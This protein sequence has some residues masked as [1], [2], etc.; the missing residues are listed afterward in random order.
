MKDEMKVVSQGLIHTWEQDFLSD[1]WELKRDGKL[2]GAAE[3]VGGSW[4][5]TDA[6]GIVIAFR[7]DEKTARHCLEL[8]VV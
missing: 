6:E 3:P 7:P 8:L 1:R 5:V 4:Q 2:I